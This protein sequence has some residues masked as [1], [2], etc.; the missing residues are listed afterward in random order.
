MAKKG[1]PRNP[2]GSVLIRISVLP[3]IAAWLDELSAFGLYGNN[4]SE[5]ARHF[6]LEGVRDELRG[7][8]FLKTRPPAGRISELPDDEQV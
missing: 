5:V 7:E 1:R 6:V 8:G 2:D 3:T 4:R